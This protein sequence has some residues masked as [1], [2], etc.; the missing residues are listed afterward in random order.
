M[1]QVLACCAQ[2]DTVFMQH[3]QEPS[4]TEGASMNTSVTATKLGLRGWPKI[5]EEL[6]VERDI[7]LLGETG[8]RYHVQHVSSGTTV[9]LIRNARS[10]GLEVSGEASPHHLLLDDRACD[11]YDT[12]AK[13]NPPLR[14]EAD[15]HALRQGVADGT[16]TVL[17]TDHAPHTLEEKALD[18]ESAP[19]GIV[20][21][22]CALALYAKALI[23]TGLIEWPRLIALLSIEPARL[24]GLA[25]Q[26]IG[27]LDAGLPADITIIDPECEWTIRTT[28]FVGKGRNCPFEGVGGEGACTGHHHRRHARDR[29]SLQLDFRLSAGWIRPAYCPHSL[30]CPQLE[31][32]TVRSSPLTTPSPVRSSGQLRQRPQAAMR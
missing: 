18:F 24:V 22:E 23:D 27:R 14:S 17:A 21:L 6:V 12:M 32:K 25:E 16:I 1:R 15:I 8:G 30:V 13:M 5:A 31:I 26:G 7:R 2:H 10:A 4:L 3:A 28:E 20:G 29:R 9:E 19:F 11:G